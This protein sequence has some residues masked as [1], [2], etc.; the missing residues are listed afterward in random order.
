[1][2]KL[3][4]LIFIWHFIFFPEGSC[5][6]FKNYVVLLIAP[7]IIV[8]YLRKKTYL[9]I[10]WPE[11]TELNVKPFKPLL[12]DNEN[13]TQADIKGILNLPQDFT[14]NLLKKQFECFVP[15]PP[16]PL[17]DPELAALIKVGSRIVRQKVWRYETRME[18]V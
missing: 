11:F 7:M 6:N 16:P 3:F 5:D 2:G 12:V 9:K 1:M 4:I 14:D 17:S 13:I 15:P 8:K 18:E 10:S